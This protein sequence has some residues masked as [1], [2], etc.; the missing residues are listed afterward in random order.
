MKRRVYL[1]TTIVSYLVARPSRDLVVAAHQELTSEWWADQQ[2]K[3]DLFISDLVLHEASRGDPSAAA[4]RG[5]LLAGIPVLPTNEELNILAEQLISSGMIPPKSTADA[6][7][8]AIATAQ[9]WS[10]C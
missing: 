5:H 3:F 6:L 10:S 1:E 2:A 4:K 8:V 7:Q 9:A